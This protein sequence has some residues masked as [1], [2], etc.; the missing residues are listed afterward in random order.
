MVANLKVADPQ[1][2]EPV[3]PDGSAVGEIIVQCNTTMKGYLKNPGATRE[4]FDG[5]WLR[6]GDLAVMHSD[7]YMEIQDRSK[8]V[9]ISGG[10]NISSLKVEEVL[11]RHPKVMQAAVVPKPDEKWGEAPCA[12]VALKP[13][14]RPLQTRLSSGAAQIWRT[15]KRPVRWYSVR[16]PRPPLERSRSS[17]CGSAP[18]GWGPDSDER[19][20]RP[21]PALDISPNPPKDR[22]GRREDSGRG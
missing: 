6:S 5:G 8:D 1:T 14:V 10:E 7:G 13:G 19:R 18:E 11:Y 22:D 21:S 20:T 15:S 16:F 3:P 9:I 2:M 17:L 4:A 12:F